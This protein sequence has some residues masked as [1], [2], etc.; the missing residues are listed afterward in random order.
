MGSVLPVAHNCDIFYGGLV[1]IQKKDLKYITAYSSVSHCGFVLFGLMTLTLFGLEGAM[2]QSFSHGIM[3]ALFFALIGTVYERTHTRELDKLG[4][5]MQVMPFAGVCYFI[6]GFAA[7]GL[8]GMT[9]FVAEITIFLGG[10][11]SDNSII[12]LLTLLACA[13]IVI[14]AVYMLRAVTKVFFGE[15]VNP[16]YKNLAPVT[17]QEKAAFSILVFVLIFVGIFPSWLI[18]ILEFS[19]VPVMHNLSRLG[20]S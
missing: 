14:S 8:P 12:R 11:V 19:L 9:G 16:E 6:A 3:T 13:S 18:S 15:L 5:L 4:G 7:L 20:A 2:L 17:L 10:W 1:A